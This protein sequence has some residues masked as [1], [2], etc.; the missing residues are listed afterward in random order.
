MEPTIA[1]SMSY[2]SLSAIAEYFVLPDVLVREVVSATPA[3][4]T[5]AFAPGILSQAPAEGLAAALPAAGH[6][7]SAH[8][9]MKAA[10]K[11]VD[12]RDLALRPPPES[13]V[14]VAPLTG[15]GL[16][17]DYGL[18]V[19]FFIRILWIVALTPFA[20]AGAA[21]IAGSSGADLYRQVTE[22]VPQ[23][24]L[25]ADWSAQYPVVFVIVALL[26]Y[27]L[28]I[29]ALFQAPSGLHV[30]R[31]G[32]RVTRRLWPFAKF[33]AMD[34]VADVRVSERQ[35]SLV[36]KNTSFLRRYS[37]PAPPMRTNDEARWL[38]A[39]IRRALVMF[40]MRG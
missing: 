4:G 20:L 30:N 35:I 10:M 3:S 17:V 34:Q 31:E 33:H 39:H 24:V 1:A 21:R 32:V 23:A 29:W 8:E 7:L 11:P 13:R 14:R 5:P 36:R 15:E 2:G 27:V 19:G 16:S 28:P 12:E 18:T 9:F 25:A 6:D 38:A 22:L 37:F 40:G 26:F